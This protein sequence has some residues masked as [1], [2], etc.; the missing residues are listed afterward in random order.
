MYYLENEYC[1][2]FININWKKSKV[3]IIH[4]VCRCKCVFTDHLLGTFFG[5]FFKEDRLLSS[6]CR[7]KKY[8]VF[9]EKKQSSMM[10]NGPHFFMDSQN[11]T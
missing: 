4:L 3:N 6:D 10:W 5:F 7:S 11:F 8:E 2:R 9:M 1:T